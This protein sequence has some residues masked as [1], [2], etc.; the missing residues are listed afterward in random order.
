MSKVQAYDTEGGSL[1][2]PDPCLY[3]KV[4]LGNLF[5]LNHAIDVQ[6]FNEDK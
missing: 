2:R 4:F 5:P 6:F 1:S 3:L